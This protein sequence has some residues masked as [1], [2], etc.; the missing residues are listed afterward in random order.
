MKYIVYKTTC[1]INNKIYIGVHKTEDPKI[2][3]GY[4]GRGHFIGGTHYL[5][6]PESPLHYAIIKYGELNFNREILHTF[7]TEEL[8]YE[9]ESQIVDEKFINSLLVKIRKSVYDR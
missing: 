6:F 4:L 2:F 5:R 1:L 7:E 3:D 8:A 9:K